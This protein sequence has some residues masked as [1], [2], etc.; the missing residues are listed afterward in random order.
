MVIFPNSVMSC[1]CRAEGTEFTLTGLAA[2]KEH[3][4]QVK[5][6]NSEGES[7]PLQVISLLFGTHLICVYFLDPQTT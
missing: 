2:D 4:I 5:A 6:V 7:E 1:T 3:R